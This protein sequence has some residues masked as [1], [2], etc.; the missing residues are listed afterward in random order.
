MTMLRQQGFTHLL[1]D[2]TMLRVWEDAGWNAPRMTA[3][4]VVGAAEAHAELVWRSESGRFLYRLQE[5][6]ED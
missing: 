4:R 2:P 1:V 5:T 6:I 3:D